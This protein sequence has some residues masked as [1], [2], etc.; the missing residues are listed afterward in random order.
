MHE[1]LITW[2]VLDMG[3]ISRSGL[4]SNQVMIDG[5]Y[6]LCATITPVIVPCRQ[7]AIM[8]PKVCSWLVFTSP[9]QERAEYFTIPWTLTSQGSTGSSRTSPCSVSYVDAVLRNRTLTPVWLEQPIALATAWVV[10]G[11][12]CGPFGQYLLDVTYS[13]HWGEGFIWYWEMSGWGFVSTIAWQFQ[14][15][16]SHVCVYCKKLLV[17]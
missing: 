9:L 4:N 6:N 7:V 12:P 8:E 13:Q 15:D 3:S 14:L 17:Y 10:C 1:F 11:F 5:S 16:F 2:E